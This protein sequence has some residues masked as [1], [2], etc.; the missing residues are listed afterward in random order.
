MLLKVLLF[1]VLIGY[2][3]HRL[4]RFISTVNGSADSGSRAAKGG[5]VRV[6]S[7]PGKDKKGFDG[8]EYVDFEEVK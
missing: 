5:N 2:A 6:D 4:N 8:G 3:V 7:D 1:A